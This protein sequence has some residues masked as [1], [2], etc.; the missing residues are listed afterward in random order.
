[1]ERSR[2]AAATASD[3]TVRRSATAC[4]RAKLTLSG[5]SAANATDPQSR[6]QSESPE[7]GRR[8]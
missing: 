5:D 1:M 6:R 7:G 3:H 2:A 4:L 8:C